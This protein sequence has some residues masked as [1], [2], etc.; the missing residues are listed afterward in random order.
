LFADLINAGLDLPDPVAD[1]PPVG[2]KF[3]LTRAAY[4]DAP[5]AATC[6]ARATSAAFTA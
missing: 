4:A 2:F 1:P 3:L 6:S 5:R